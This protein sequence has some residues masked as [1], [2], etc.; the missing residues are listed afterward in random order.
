[1][2]LNIVPKRYYYEKTSSIGVF[3][4]RDVVEIPHLKESYI[5]KKGNNAHL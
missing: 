1:M 3:F 5:Q 2:K 4:S